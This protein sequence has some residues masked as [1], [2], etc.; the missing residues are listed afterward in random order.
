MIGIF[1]QWW[2][3]SIVSLF[4]ASVAPLLGLR[5]SNTFPC[6]VSRPIQ[7][8]RGLVPESALLDSKVLGYLH[9]Q[10]SWILT[11]AVLASWI[12]TDATLVSRHSLLQLSDLSSVLASKSFSFFFKSHFL[13]FSECAFFHWPQVPPLLVPHTGPACCPFNIFLCS[14]MNWH[15]PQYLAPFNAACNKVSGFKGY[16]SDHVAC[17]CHG[18]AVPATS[19][20]SLTA[21]KN[22]YLAPILFAQPL[23]NAALSSTMN[24]WHTALL[25]SLGKIGSYVEKLDPRMVRVVFFGRLTSLQ[26]IL[27]FMGTRGSEDDILHALTMKLCNV[28]LNLNMQHLEWPF[29]A[30]DEGEILAAISHVESLLDSGQPLT[31]CVITCIPRL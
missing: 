23:V 24:P 4:N 22:D 30:E 1:C 10:C 31:R 6:P 18:C 2:L 17:H 15:V 26:T 21:W 3:Y 28:A 7:I 29:A 20:Y 19:I 13:R 14:V 25:E 16:G 8:Y 9:R 27:P 5:S 12:S 11:G